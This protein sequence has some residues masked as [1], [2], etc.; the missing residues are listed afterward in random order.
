MEKAKNKIA[1]ATLFFAISGATSAFASDQ[2]VHLLTKEL[3]SKTIA[4]Y[5]ATNEKEKIA[6]SDDLKLSIKKMSKLDYMEDYRAARAMVKALASPEYAYADKEKAEHILEDAFEKNNHRKAHIFAK[7]MMDT[8]LIIYNKETAIDLM[9]ECAK[10]GNTRC[11]KSVVSERAGVQT[12]RKNAS[13]QEIS[14]TED[15]LRSIERKSLSRISAEDADYYLS[16]YNKRYH[17]NKEKLETIMFHAAAT[18][19]SSAIEVLFQMYA[20]RI[21]FEPNEEKMFKIKYLKSLQK[22]KNSREYQF[23]MKRSRELGKIGT[24]WKSDVDS[25]VARQRKVNR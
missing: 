6:A 13:K 14:F 22:G 19:D 15:K 10:Y 1:M 25:I 24:K 18:M 12:E 17:K 21:L 9:Q 4:L 20:Q 8:D 16:A 3:R 7:M 5:S 11:D 23:M 2:D